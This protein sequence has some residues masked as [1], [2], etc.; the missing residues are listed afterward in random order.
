MELQVL[1]LI[2]YC[3]FFKDYLP[4]KLYCNR[5]MLSFFLVFLI[6]RLNILWR[7]LFC[8]VFY[9]HITNPMSNLQQLPKSLLGASRCIWQS[10]SITT[11]ENSLGASAQKQSGLA[12]LSVHALII[13]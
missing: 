6:I 7:I 13:K 3:Y 11:L 2:K 4:T 10:V 12:A 1:G 9:T 8:L 5:D